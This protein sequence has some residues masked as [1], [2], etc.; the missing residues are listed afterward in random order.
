MLKNSLLPPPHLHPPQVVYAMKF[1]L[2]CCSGH[3]KT[4]L[5]TRWHHLMIILRWG[6]PLVAFGGGIVAIQAQMAL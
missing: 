6:K 5:L 2:W 3:I 4:T 1:A